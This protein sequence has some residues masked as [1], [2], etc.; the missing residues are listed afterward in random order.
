MNLKVLIPILCV[1][2][3]IFVIVRICV[4]FK[5]KIQFFSVGLDSQ[6]K[7]GELRT[8]WRL[9]K[10]CNLEDPMSLFVSVPTINSCIGMIITESRKNKT[11]DSK[12]VQ[13]FLDKL[14]KFRTRVA[15]D[16][17]GKKNIENTK[18]LD[19]GQKLTV[20]LPGKGVFA[21]K[22]FNNAREMVI[23]LPKRF[24]KKS[25]STI[26]LSSEEW[27]G[28]NITV[29]FWRKGDAMYSCI[30]PVLDAGVFQG[31]PALFLKQSNQL[32]RNQKRQSVR[33]ECQIYAQMFI[34]KAPVIDFTEVSNAGGYR[35][36]L[37]DISEDGALIRIGGKG[38]SNV[39]IKLQFQIEDTFIM[40]YGEVKGVEY[41]PEINQSKLHFECKHI[42]PIMRNAILTF[43]Y[44]VIPDDQKEINEAIM[45]TAQDIDPSEENVDANGDIKVNLGKSSDTDIIRKPEAAIGRVE[46][47][48]DEVPDDVNIDDNGDVHLDD[49]LELL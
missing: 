46:G 13:D 45:Q 49:T 44:K 41:N 27:I 17:E 9:A 37:E 12:K 42:D 7:F 33:S 1:I 18:Y 21:S 30:T 26:I 34:I 20:I 23:E 14:Y 24:D 38:V 11:H 16:V 31:D 48:D 39:Q 43:V 2:V 36:L 10:N 3:G 4:V 35:C 40:M 32:V 25:N 19:A 8:L 22:I 28:R 29:F 6:F 15:L 5:D 47:Y